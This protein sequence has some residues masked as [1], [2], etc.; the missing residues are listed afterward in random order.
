M[1]SKL[2]LRKCNS[3]IC[4]FFAFVQKCKASMLGQMVLEKLARYNNLVVFNSPGF[5][6]RQG[7]IEFKILCSKE[8][9]FIG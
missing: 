6:S 5:R 8:L 1:G 7:R 4:R 3:H 9:V 2:K